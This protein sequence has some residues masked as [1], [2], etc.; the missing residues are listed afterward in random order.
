MPTCKTDLEQRLYDTLK[1]ITR[2]DTPERLKKYGE[3][4]YGA[5]GEECVEMAYENVLSE[6][7]QGLRGIRARKMGGR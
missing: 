2:Y 4:V 6:A 1:R 3:R 7:K 5:S